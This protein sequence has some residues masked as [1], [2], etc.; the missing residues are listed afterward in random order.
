MIPRK[1][2]REERGR[3]IA[4]NGEVRR[5]NGDRYEVISQSGNGIY[6]ILFSSKGWA[7]DCPDYQTRNVK[8]KHIHAVEFSLK[9]RNE[10]KESIVVAPISVTSCIK[11]HSEDI[12]KFGIRR[13]KNTAIQRFRCRSCRK[14]FSLNLGF[15]KMRNNPKAITTA[16]QLYFSGESLRNTKLALKMMGVSVSHVTI[17]KWI[18]KYVRLMNNYL[19]RITPQVSGVWRTDEMYVKFSGKMNYVFAMMDDET[20]YWIAQQVAEHKGTSDVTPMFRDAVETTE[21]KPFLLISDGARN[22]DEAFHK[23]YYSNKLDCKHIRHISLKGDK[24]NNKMERLNGETRD[25][26]KVCRGLKNPNTPIL[27]GIQLYHN[28]VRPH[29]ALD[30]KTPAE[31]AGIKVQ[32]DDKWMTIIQNAADEGRRTPT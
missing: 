32:G 27:K 12:E 18:G 10:V 28:Y 20:R 1:T 17:Y 2:T 31:V 26:E 29:A 24:N 15:E 14:T 19:E 22:F 7:C 23:E 4:E 11:C 9:L 5:I 30:G 16:M 21:K 3:A 6:R 13:N 25:R 8:C